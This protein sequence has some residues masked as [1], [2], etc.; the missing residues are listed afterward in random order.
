MSK[1]A[2]KLDEDR[3]R[4]VLSRLLAPAVVDRVIEECRSEE[5]APASKPTREQIDTAMR[6]LE[7]RDR[8]KGRR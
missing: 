6:R 7:E 5:P 8:K 3:V 2:N 1:P 4:A